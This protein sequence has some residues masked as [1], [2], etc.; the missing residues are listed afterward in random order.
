MFWLHVFSSLLAADISSQPRH[1]II[2]L[3]ARVGN[4]GFDAISFTAQGFRKRDLRSVRLC[5][6]AA[7]Q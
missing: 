3:S 1:T 2:G 6:I 4:P 5:E 7:V